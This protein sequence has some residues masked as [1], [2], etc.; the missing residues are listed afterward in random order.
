VLWSASAAVEP[1][2][3][4]DWSRTLRITGTTL[5]ESLDRGSPVLD[6]PPGTLN[7]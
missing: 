3:I 2:G 4:G 1:S 5:Y 7:A 6:G